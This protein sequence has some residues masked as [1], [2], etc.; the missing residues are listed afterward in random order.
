MIAR[1]E[2]PQRLF[3][4]PQGGAQ[5]ADEWASRLVSLLHFGGGAAPVDLVDTAALYTN[6]GTAIIAP[7]GAGVGLRTAA[8][9]ES[10]AIA[11]NALSGFSGYCTLVMFWPETEIY[12]V[13]G[14]SGAIP[15]SVGSTIY[16]QFYS[17]G[18]SVYPMGGV[19]P[20][21]LDSTPWGSKN[22][23][24]IIRSAGDQAIFFNRKKYAASGMQ[25]LPAGAKTVRVGSHNGDNGYNF[26][27]TTAVIA[28]VGGVV[29]DDEA[30]AILDNP[31][32]FYKSPEYRN[33]TISAGAPLSPPTL[34]NLV[35]SNITTGGARH[36]VTLAYA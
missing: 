27:G 35:A 17:N 10:H 34:S 19:S 28:V 6:A 36:T 18:A 13:Q 3:A 4:Q 23:C 16:N 11:L 1:I 33:V 24:V 12:T 31:F 21:A 9:A 2:T 29:S 8:G 14:A 7:S 20:V 32:Q 26:S 25:P 22:Q 15:W 30:F 5:V